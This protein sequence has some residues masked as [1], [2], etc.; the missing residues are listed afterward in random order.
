[1]RRAPVFHRGGTAVPPHAP[2]QLLEISLAP[3]ARAHDVALLPGVLG[4]EAHE[5]LRL[6]LAAEWASHAREDPIAA[7]H[8]ARKAPPPVLDEIAEG[9]RSAAERAHAELPD[10]VARVLPARGER[11][12]ERRAESGGGEEGDDFRRQSDGGVH[13]AHSP[14]RRKERGR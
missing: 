10:T 9:G 5:V 4:L 1:M 2:V 13:V 3:A 6:P 14:L 7:A 12:L 11:L 8:R